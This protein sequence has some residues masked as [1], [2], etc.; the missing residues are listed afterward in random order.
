MS[1]SK[2]LVVTPSFFGWTGESVNERQLI[3]SLARKSEKVYV[4]SFAGFKQVFT[5]RR[6]ELKVVR[7][8]NITVFPVPFP[9]I[10]P[11]VTTISFFFISYIFASVTTFF[12]IFGLVDYIYIRNAIL[13]PGFTSFRFLAN[14]TI[15]KIPAIAEEEIQASSSVK[16]TIG[17]FCAFCNRLAIMKSKRVAVIGEAIGSLICDKLGVKPTKPFLH[18]PAGIDEKLMERVKWK[19]K[20][21]KIHG[22]KRNWRNVGFIGSMYWWQGVPL[23]AKSMSI[24]NKKIPNVKFIVIG[25]GPQR[26]VVESICKK[27]GINWVI[28]G[29]LPH[30][31]ALERLATLNVMVLSSLKVST[32]ELIV[33]IK[34]MEAWALGVPFV[35][36]DHEVLVKRYKHL[37]DLIYCKP[38]SQSIADGIL[39]LLEDEQLMLK[40][41]KRGPTLAYEFSYDKISE[42][43]LNALTE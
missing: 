36:T 7:T 29:Y 33:H 5:K 30:E 24:V 42:R 31:E 35:V 16:N 18:I 11:L 34:L 26:K 1:R 25:D 13:S 9:D 3:T 8:P 20:K 38:E 6:N 21:Q 14:K 10:H 12:R 41:S 17:K 43:L 19:I 40:I 28:T 23:L 37:Q 15:V 4:F 22:I 32:M 2:I 39:T 27:E